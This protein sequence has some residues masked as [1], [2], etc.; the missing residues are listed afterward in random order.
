[1]H[2]RKSF[3]RSFVFYSGHDKAWQVFPDDSCQAEKTY[4]GKLASVQKAV[5]QLAEGARQSFT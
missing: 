4:D 1:M 2:W 3:L 5:H